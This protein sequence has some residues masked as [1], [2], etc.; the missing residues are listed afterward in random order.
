VPFKAW[1]ER[2][3]GFRIGYTLNT[4]IG[5]GDTEVTVLQLA[6]AYAALANGGQLW[7]P[8]LAL[9]VETAEG[10]VVAEYPPRLRRRVEV[11]HHSLELVQRGLYGVV[12]EA[13]G[14]AHGARVAGLSVAGK[15]GTA[16][17]R[18]MT[19]QAASGEWNPTRDHAWFAGYAPADD[20]RIAVVVLVEHGG[21]GGYVAA[22]VAMEIIK[23]WTELSAPSA[24]PV[25]A[26]DD[27]P[28]DEPVPA[29]AGVDP[30]R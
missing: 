26:E 30:A 12:N 22:P 11:S 9:R 18:K 13:K 15:T 2:T 19:R 25:A 4:V 8:Q 24:P 29:A 10:K 14:T 1:Y 23:A 27:E 17:V 16:Q 5:Q 6:L 3:G 7:V 21:K 20:P 28:R